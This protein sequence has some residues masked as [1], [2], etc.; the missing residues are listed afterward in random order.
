MRAKATSA[1]SGEPTV[2]LAVEPIRDFRIPT[3]GEAARNNDYAS[4]DSLYT[5]A[6]ERG[7]NV[8]AYAALHEL[9]SYQMS[10][11]IGAFYGEELHDRFARAYPGYANFI[12]EYRIVDSHG[13]V[14]YPTAETREFL[15]ERA[16]NNER[17]P[18]VLLADASD[19]IAT[20]PHATK[21][22]RFHKAALEK[23]HAKTV[24]AAG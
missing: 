22:V 13:S 20:E 23:P 8:A 21:R 5:T 11:P 10:S 6:K 7:E 12:A 19:S 24:G 4:F 3:L 15:L 18:R 17:A 16:K 14:F 9:W 1:T 2:F